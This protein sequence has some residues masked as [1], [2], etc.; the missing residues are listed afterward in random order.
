[1]Q[2]FSDNPVLRSQLESQVDFMTELTNKTVD[3]LRQLSELNMKLARQTI[4]ASIYSSRE[5]LNCSDP[6]QLAQA[7]MKQ[8][9][10]AAERVRTYQQHL[11]NVLAGAQVDFAHTAE[12]RLPAAGRSASA[13]ADDMAR[14]AAAAANV[15]AGAADSARPPWP[16]ND[17]P[18]GA[19][20]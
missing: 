13:A 6:A 18:T 10:P 1:M 12:A 9:Q 15:A 17:K 19:P 5:L 2:L 20:H 7:V 11:L 14:H 8:V 4:E 16:D 3:T